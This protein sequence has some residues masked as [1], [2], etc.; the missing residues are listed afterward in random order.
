MNRSLLAL[1]AVVALVAAG[2][3]E[4]EQEAAVDDNPLAAL[5][6]AATKTAEVDSMRQTL[7]MDAAFGG[8]ELSM[9]GEGSF[10]ADSQ[11]GTM[12]AT[13]VEGG[14]EIEFEAISVDGTL[15]IK[16]DAF[17]LPAGK[18]W[19]KAPDAPTSTMEP[20]AFV[21]FLQESEGVENV[22]TEEIRGEQTTHFRGPLDLER[23][24][25]ASDSPVLDR[26]K[27]SPDAKDF[28]IVVDVWVMDD[29]LPARIAMKLT[30]TG[31]NAGEMTMATD[32]LEYD[33]PIDVEAP[34]AGKVANRLG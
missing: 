19:L 18:E 33:V 17:P 32:I 3:G 6:T 20:A 12:T 5:N 25:Q 30:T 2:C 13:I 31:D 22:G 8:E 7:T 14:E 16:G 9:E 26:L 4:A 11:D 28:D 23:L 34:P 24:A 10:T 1:A 27:S 29:D 15:Y 21:R